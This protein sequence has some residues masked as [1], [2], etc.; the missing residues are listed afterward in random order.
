[1]Q[2]LTAEDFGVL[3]TIGTGS[4]LSA[5]EQGRGIGT[6]MRAAV[7]H[8]GFEVLG[9]ELAITG[10]FATNKGSISVS[11]KLGYLANGIRRD[12]VRDAAGDTV[13]VPASARALGRHWH[14]FPVDVEGFPGCESLFGLDR[15]GRRARERDR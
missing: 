2:Q 4:W 5:G 7:L 3:R 13:S 8:F 12:R 15:T 1:M 9:A 14:A 11:Q 6:E 10:A